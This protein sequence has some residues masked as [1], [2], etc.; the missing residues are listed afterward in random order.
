[1][2]VLMETVVE[3][4]RGEWSPVSAPDS[5]WVWKI[6]MLTL[7]GAVEPYSHETKLSGANRDVE[8]SIFLVQLTTRRIGNHTRLTSCLL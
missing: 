2:T 5:A 6:S 1:M 4:G 8:N 7:D 3:S